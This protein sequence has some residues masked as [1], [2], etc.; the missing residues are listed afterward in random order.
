MTIFSLGSCACYFVYLYAVCS[1]CSC[2]HGYEN[3][4]GALTEV[5]ERAAEAGTQPGSV[6]FNTTRTTA[7]VITD[8]TMTKSRS[9]RRLH[10][11]R[12]LRPDGKREV[13]LYNPTAVTKA[14]NESVEDRTLD[15]TSY[16]TV[17]F[18]GLLVKLGFHVS[19]DSVSNKELGVRVLMHE[20]QIRDLTSTGFT[21]LTQYQNETDYL[22]FTDD[23][24]G[25][26]LYSDIIDDQESAQE[27]YIKMA[28]DP[29]YLC[30]EG[31]ETCAAKPKK[32]FY[33]S[34]QTVD[35]IYQRLN[36][37]AGEETEWVRTSSMGKTY[38]GRDQTMYTITNYANPNWGSNKVVFYYCGTHP[39]ELI[40]T[41]TC[42]WII[43]QL[44]E[45]EKVGSS[46]SLFSNGLLNEV[47]VVILPYLNVDGAYHTHK[48]NNDIFVLK[49]ALDDGLLD[50]DENT[51]LWYK[52]ANA[53][54]WRKTMQ[55]NEIRCKAASSWRDVGVAEMDLPDMPQFDS[56]LC[57]DWD[58]FWGVDL[59]RNF[60]SHWMG[61]GAS[62]SIYRAAYAGLYPADQ[63]E[64]QNIMKFVSDLAEENKLLTVTDIH[65]C[66]NVWLL[67]N[68]WNR[69]KTSQQ[70]FPYCVETYG[71]SYD[72]IIQEEWAKAITD[73]IYNVNKNQFEYGSITT[74]IYPAA[75]SS[76]DWYYEKLGILYAG[77]PEITIDT[78]RYDGLTT[79]GGEPDFILPSVKEI[80][81]GMIAAVKFA[82]EN[83]PDEVISNKNNFPIPNP[84]YSV[85]YLC[86]SI[87]ADAKNENL[88]EKTCGDVDV[89]P[90]EL[91][92]DEIPA[93]I[94]SG[95][96][97]CGKYLQSVDDKTGVATYITVDRDM[98]FRLICPDAC[99]TG[100]PTDMPSEPPTIPNNCFDDP[101][102]K[103]QGKNKM[104]CKWID[105]SENKDNLCK[106]RT[107]KK[108][109]QIVCGECCADDP[110]GIKNKKCA[111]FLEEEAKRKKQCKK[112]TVNTPCALTCGRCCYS[113]RD[114]KFTV[115]QNE[116]PCAFI[117]KEA[118]I[119][120]FCKGNTKLKCGVECGCE[121]YTVKLSEPPAQKPVSAPVDD[122]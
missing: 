78:R 13:F 15:G 99:S 75:G 46:N 96:H 66:L 57:I 20:D 86:D 114:Y 100:N 11:R 1:R 94:G 6:D 25:N 24:L 58:M 70:A 122:D 79:F 82:L 45:E 65:C 33:A 51:K 32:E 63:V 22:L 29:K 52:Y 64:T 73:A 17:D 117:N 31:T 18:H 2:C 7:T 27:R 98:T 81:A 62:S 50:N 121:D 16:T 102:F 4:V 85:K 26:R 61:G 80:Y 110:A 74:K 90:F 36:N 77:A 42:P 111:I 84:G 5:Q 39:R 103:F 101:S 69:C 56:Q 116:K 107:V 88:C 112:S 28:S 97:P 92:P 89:F 30:M 3:V 49:Q 34:Y 119:T 108:A 48:Y 14:T 8:P 35:T 55:R 38:E 71:E 53:R 113:D 83:P 109:C 106:K 10:G 91:K 41:M 12:Q 43:E 72:L 44:L 104:T 59:N 95:I 93:L 105:Q 40:A 23:D 67:P 19:E 37:L 47:T 54:M 9:R 115:N 68:G 87:S 60:P 21:G 118:K 120:K 76:I